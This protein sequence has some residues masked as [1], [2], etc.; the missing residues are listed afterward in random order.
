MATLTPAILLSTGNPTERQIA[1]TTLR[2][3]INCS[4]VCNIIQ[5]HLLN[6]SAC[7][8]SWQHDYTDTSN[9]GLKGNTSQYVFSGGATTR[10]KLCSCNW[11]LC[12]LPLA[13]LHHSLCCVIKHPDKPVCGPNIPGPKFPLYLANLFHFNVWKR[14]VLYETIQASAGPQV[15]LRSQH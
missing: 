14:G 5:H 9:A 8:Y 4:R 6:V 15:P 13:L 7:V 11:C 2:G 3:A 12:R 1:G 10:S